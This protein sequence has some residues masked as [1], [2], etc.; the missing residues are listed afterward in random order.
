MIYY[1]SYVL[2]NCLIKMKKLILILIFIIN[3]LNC[4]TD[5]VKT[6]AI[7][8]HI[9]DGDTFSAQ[10]ILNSDIKISVRVRIIGLDTPEISGLCKKEKQ[11]ALRAKKRLGEILKI[12]SIVYLSKI[13]DDKYLGRIDA[14]VEQNNTNVADILIKEGLARRYFGGKRKPWCK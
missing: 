2:Y 8:Q 5:K 14:V 12:G 7:V 10:V 4:S 13:K 1:M 9:I 6:K 11:M 3:S